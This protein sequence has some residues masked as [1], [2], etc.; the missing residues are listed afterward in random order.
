M[1]VA[2]FIIRLEINKRNDGNKKCGNHTLFNNLFSM[3]FAV[4]QIVLI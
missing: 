1:T 3:K 2:I 4:G